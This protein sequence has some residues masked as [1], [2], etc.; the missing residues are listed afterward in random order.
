MK[1]FLKYLIFSLL[2]LILLLSIVFAFLYYTADMKQ[3]DL[4]VNDLPTY[5]LVETD[6]LRIYGNNRLELKKSGLWEMHL[7]GD[8]FER[9]YA[10]GKLMP[11][12]LH[13]QE[14]V[15]VDQIKK[16]IP[17]D[18]Y[19]KFLRFMLVLFNRNL[20][21]YV[22]EENRKEIYGISLSCTDEFNAIGT[23][24]QRQLNYHAAHDI[25]HAMQDYMLVG[26]SSFG[27]WGSE[28]PD[29]TLLIGR[30]FD[31]YVG[32]DFAKNKLVTICQPDKGYRFI[33]VGWP[34]MT[35]VLSGMNEA[36]LTV[37]INAAKS[38][39][40]TSAATPISILARL[41]LQYASTI[42][43]AYA[44]AEQH[45]TFVSESLL[46]GSAADGKASVIE[47]SPDTIALYQSGNDRIISTNHFQSETFAADKRNV[48]NIQTSDSPYRYER[49]N[50]LLDEWRPVSPSKAAR[51]LRDYY[52]KDYRD[53][54]FANEKAINQFIA[55]HSIIF[56]PE[57]RLMWVSTSPWQLGE[58]IAYNLEGAIDS[59]TIPADPALRLGL[60]RIIYNYRDGIDY[61]KTSIRNGAPEED[62]LYIQEFVTIN[63]ENFY[64]YELAGDWYAASGDDKQAIVSW[65]LALS[66]DIYKKSDRIRIQKKI[67]KHR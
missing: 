48:E 1:R 51:I 41:I 34:G 58:Y 3:P 43:E 56:Q 31:F 22:P 57:K 55:H 23:P 4:S 6:S 14:K 60:D 52:G 18:G 54:G 63:M 46:I 17:S 65:I 37:T 24:Y 62:R 15:F 10:A 50:E 64:T 42:N 33:S 12:L 36:G 7:S 9:G 53:I 44:I 49:L 38:T 30:N 66:K 40:P 20:G 8:A 67:N 39:I 26:C 35:G 47:K 59:L 21:N 2:A 5:Q 45:T 32:D 16:I 11:D 27:V 61:I 13:Y 19:L 29:S 25:G 28:R